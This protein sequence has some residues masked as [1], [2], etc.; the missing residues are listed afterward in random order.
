MNAESVICSCDHCGQNIEFDLA[1]FESSGADALGT[2]GQTINC[3][4]CARSTVLRI[5][6]EK[7]IEPPPVVKSPPPPATPPPAKRSDLSDCP[8]CN[9]LISSYATSCPRCGR[10]YPGKGDWIFK[11]SY[12]TKTRVAGI[13][14]FMIG[15]GL[16]LTGCLDDA[17]AKS[18]IQ[19]SPAYIQMFAGV[20]LSAV[21]IV[22]Y[23]TALIIESIENSH[24]K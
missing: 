24:L 20:L 2:L 9:N 21:S 23:S 13:L 16:C 18:A 11:K 17:A 12:Q 19:Q 1:D 10:P 14:G 4:H 6:Y 3:P 7:P 15:M 5:P 8:S 22:I